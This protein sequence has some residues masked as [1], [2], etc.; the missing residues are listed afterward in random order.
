MRKGTGVRWAGLLAAL[1]V[2]WAAGPPAVRADGPLVSVVT[3]TTPG[4]AAAHGL[5]KLI[6]ALQARGASCERTP[7][8]DRARGKFLVAAGLAGSDGP[9]ARAPE[10]GGR[11]APQG[12]EAVGAR[13][14]EVRGET[15]GGDG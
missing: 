7:S 3:G 8:L 14:A 9:A 1:G 4:P 6:A 13:R 15:G 2:A 12:P 5:E 11:P 10:E